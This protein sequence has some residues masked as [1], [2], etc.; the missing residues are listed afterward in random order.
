MASYGRLL[1]SPG[2][3]RIMLAQLTARLPNGMLSLAYLLHVEGVF[4]SYGA[5]G[6]VLATTS[7]GQA[8]AG[9][10]LGRWMGA[11]GMRPVLA[12][13]TA[14]SAATMLTI[15]FAPM[16]LAGYAAVGFLGGLSL[17]PVQPAVRTI[18]PKIVNSTQLTLL[19]SLDSSA[20]ELI[21]IASPVLITFVSVQV[22]TQLGILL[23]VAF[24]VGGGAWFIASPE[25]G[26][27]RIPRSKRR[28]GLVL[29]RPPVLLAT[30]ISILLIGCC[31]ALEA[32]VVASFGDTGPQ[33]G[34]VLAI[35]SVASLVGGLAFGDIP[36]GP[37]ALGRRML[38]VTVG[39]VLAALA[40]GY[41]A[42]EPDAAGQFGSAQFWALAGTLAISGLGIAPCMAV[43]FA[44]VSVSVR[45]SD[46]A[47]AY[48]WVGTGQLIGGAAGSAVTGFL[49]DAHGAAGGF[50]AGAAFAALGTLIA[51]ALR[52]AHPDLRGRDA[53][54]L[55]DTAPVPLTPS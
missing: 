38:V 18:Y 54:P 11:W 47:E 53:S 3:L 21:W 36:I 28:F 13:T 4:H 20:Q 55:P 14:V 27:V 25:L 10:L 42:T 52:R 34:I 46:T 16:S 41:F 37:T 50:A 22:S 6:I 19:F 45:F 31:A 33:S 32:S 24:L 48:G 40:A 44:I 1:R 17:P 7:V 5:A 29:A 35:W 30:V 43:M 51:F 49:I 2:V 39:T 26:K 12:L 8:I 9:P 15:A 23:A